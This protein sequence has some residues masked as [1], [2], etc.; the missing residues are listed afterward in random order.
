MAK[1]IL[2]NVTILI[3]H[4]YHN[5]WYKWMVN[6]HLPEMMSTGFFESFKMSKILGVDEEQGVN[7]AVQYI[8]RSVHDFIEYRDH[9]AKKMQEKH[10]KKFASKYVAVR[11]VME[12]VEEGWHAV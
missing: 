6:I 5:E 11:T 4:A 1:K 7:Y 2:Y 3:D 8:S 9:H 10:Q 12:I